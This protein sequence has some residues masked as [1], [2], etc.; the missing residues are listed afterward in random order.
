VASRERSSVRACLARWRVPFAACLLTGWLFG[1]AL[2]MPAPPNAPPAAQ[3]N[4]STPPRALVIGLGLGNIGA[5]AAPTGAA[6]AAS[7]AGVAVA[8]EL[9]AFEVFGKVQGVF[10]RKHTQRRA[11]ELGL[12]GWVANTAAKTV[13][14]EVSPPR[15]SS[16]P[17]DVRIDLFP[18][19]SAFR[20]R[21]M[22][23][24]VRF[25]GRGRR[26]DVCGRL[27]GGWAAGQAE[28]NGGLASPDREP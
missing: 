9:Y 8:A 27:A 2:T 19:P 14:G 23:V 21:Q 18:P 17:V 13:V 20:F 28:A 10:F 4:P 11:Q 24:S 7:A 3:P 22:L 15:C 1:A 16:L 6:G 26:G 5:M 25:V 12:A